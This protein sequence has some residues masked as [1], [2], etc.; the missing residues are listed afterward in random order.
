MVRP[1]GCL[2]HAEKCLSKD[3]AVGCD[4]L[5]PHI[6]LKL[7]YGEANAERFKTFADFVRMVANGELTPTASAHLRTC[8]IT[9]K[10]EGSKVRNLG[11]ESLLARLADKIIVKAVINEMAA[12]ALQGIAFGSGAPHGSD[13]VAFRA[14]LCMQ[15]GKE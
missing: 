15:E 9:A 6:L 5:T 3:D 14:K 7:F 4:A 13:T 8:R 2:H 1:A 12:P 11:I 10:R